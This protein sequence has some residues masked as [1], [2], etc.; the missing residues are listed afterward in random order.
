VPPAFAEEIGSEILRGGA[1]ISLEAGVALAG[2]HTIQ[3]EEPKYGL[4][5]LGFVHPDRIITKTGA[6]PGDRLYLTKP[7]GMGVTTS[8]LKK[9]KAD[10][11]DVQEAVGWM[12]NLNRDASQIARAAGVRGGTDVTGFSLLGHAAE[13]AAGSGVRLRIQYDRI[14]LISCAEKYAQAWHFPGGASDNRLYF[15]DQVT[16]SGDLEEWELMLMFDPQT[17]GGLLLSVPEASAEL[18]EKTAAEKDLAVWEVGSV[19]DGQGIE[20]IS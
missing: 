17:N 18:F 3:D 20:V 8:A 13:M 14:P 1:E 12:R 15:Q 5:V 6:R 11:A 2:G 7:L 19:E 10:P 4:V 9:Q 16:V